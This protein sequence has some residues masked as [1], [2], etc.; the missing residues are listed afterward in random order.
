MNRKIVNISQIVTLLMTIHVAAQNQTMQRSAVKSPESYAFEKYGNV[1][2]NLYTGAVDLKVPVTSIEENGVSIPI[3]LSYDSSGFIPHKKSEVAGV[4]WTLVAG[5][6][7]TRTLKGAP[8][9]YVGNPNA[10]GIF[11]YP[12][13]VHGFLKGVRTNPSTNTSAYNLY[14]GTG[15]IDTNNNTIAWTMGPTSDPSNAYEGTPDIFSF[16]AMGLSGKF[17]VGNDGNVLVESSDPNIKVDLSQMALYGGHSFCGNDIVSIIKIIDGNGNQYIF[18]GDLS[19][20]ELA[21]YNSN[22][23]FQEGFSGFPTISGFSLS[24]IIF[25]DGKTVDFNYFQGSLQQQ[26][27]FCHNPNILSGT[28]TNP[29]LSI[30][31]Y[32]QQGARGDDWWFC[33]AAGGP[34]QACGGGVITYGGETESFSLLKKSVLT[35]IR[36]DNYEIKINYLNTGYPIKHRYSAPKYLNEWV[37][38]NV[39][40]Y[41]YNKLIKKT[42]LSYDHLGGEY[43]RPFLRSVK[44]NFSNQEYT[45]SYNTSYPLP[46]YYTKGIDHW[47]YWNG[48]D[49]NVY[50]APVQDYNYDTGDYTLVN[51]YRDPSPYFFNQGLLNRVNYPTKG[52]S[53]F[54]YEPHSYRKRLERN[55]ASNF[56]PVLTNNSGFAGGARIKEIKNYSEGVLASQKEYKYTTALEDTSSS[57]I[58]MHWPR[59]LYYWEFT[60]QGDFGPEWHKTYIKTSSNI[61]QS[62]LDSYNVGYSKV[63]EIDTNKG[64]TEHNFSTYETHPDQIMP[65]ADNIRE[66][67]QTYA[68]IK[69]VNLYKNFNNLY[70]IDKS[71]LRG[72]LLNQKYFSQA[73]MINPVKMVDFEYTDNMAFNPNNSADD[74]NYVSVN[75]MSGK[76][77]QGYRKYM[78]S[79]Y[80]KKKTVRDYFN[81]SEVKTETEYFYE[82]SKNLNLSREVIK[83]S[84]ATE[85]KTSYQYLKDIFHGAPNQPASFVP[86]YAFM[87]NLLA[88]N[89]SSIPLVTT[90][91]RNNNFLSRIQT[92]YEFNSNNTILT[93]PKKQLSYTEDKI[94]SSQSLIGLPDTSFGTEEVVYDLY[95]DKGN[96]QQYTTKDGV[97]TTIIWGYN[98]TLPIARIVGAK[99]SDIPASIIT[100]LV[101]ASII[102]AQAVPMSDETTFM[103]A[104]DL[105]RKDVSLSGYQVTTYSHDPLIGIRSITSP[106]GIREVYKYDTAGRLKE[107]RENSFSGN[108]LK[109]YNYNFKP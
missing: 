87:M 9:E 101:N 17:V 39:E 75:H 42:Q 74:N 28:A 103:N 5:G 83:N 8:D 107:V 30:E 68:N 56:L 93:L 61:I 20:Y 63:F 96:L 40:T 86:P 45:F 91:Y 90:K 41:S 14:G 105:F 53:T 55:S 59:Y 27:D 50:L 38:D 48:L 54:E 11:G 1:P 79:S 3:T 51:S 92:L 13:D 29:T 78:N 94:V 24:K 52:Y 106:S 12:R 98:K 57:G 10:P 21:Y 49:S 70:S 109:E 43:K 31:A 108:L 81:G 76:W 99:L 22:V 89:M 71:I 102:D 34:A 77:V 19:K 62:S 2:V 58:L 18:G 64:Y 35:S 69:P 36:Y 88:K 46:P 80:L 26:Y 73:D 16:Y 67:V 104:L 32:S 15:K 47:G 82:S 6:R 60:Q 23:L 72:K 25:N 7:I 95:D 4:N 65:D 37:I 85:L 97:S 84:D 100:T 66:Y 44:D 33:L